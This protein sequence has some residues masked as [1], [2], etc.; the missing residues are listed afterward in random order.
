MSKGSDNH[1]PEQYSQITEVFY[2]V[3]GNRYVYICILM[4]VGAIFIEEDTQVWEE[5]WG[6]SHL[7]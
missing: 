5:H 6:A 7:Q 2:A 4:L 3:D 1:I